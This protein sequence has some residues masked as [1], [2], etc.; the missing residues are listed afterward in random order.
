MDERRAVTVPDFVRKK[1]S[2]QRIVMVTAYDYPSAC[3]ADRAGV[4]AILVGD[5]LAMVVQGHAT[6]LPVTLDEMIYHVRAV[7]RA[8][9][10]ALVVGDMPFL[11]YQAG[12]D[13]AVFN[14]GR[15]LKEGGATAVKLEGGAAVVPLVRRLAAAGIPVM[16]HLGLTPQS[17]HVFGGFRVQ[18]RRV[19]AARQLLADAV[20]LA[21]AGA[22]AVVLE[23][24][25]SVVAREVTH[26]IPVP[27]IGIGAGPCCDGE[28]QVFHDLLGL[29]DEFL[30]RHT[31]RHAE[32]G[33]AAEEALRQYAEEVRTGV[34]PAEANTVRVRELEDVASWRTDGSGL[35]L[36]A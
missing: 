18:A 17:V 14:A 16:G 10:K 15:L 11:S 22:F 8:R 33:R 29:Y 9:P 28:I 1:T 36:V 25:P 19:E 26:A 7:T 4:D 27:T 13:D 5:S 21:E 23:S 12:M 24:V 20:A 31:K 34:F 32:L 35:D 3:L 6:T 2:R 30:A